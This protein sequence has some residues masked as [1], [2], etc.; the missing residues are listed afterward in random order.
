M[1]SFCFVLHVLPFL[2]TYFCGLG[3]FSDFTLAGGYPA[4]FIML[5]FW[6]WFGCYLLSCRHWDL[7]I[8]RLVLSTWNEKRT[9][10]IV[11]LCVDSNVLIVL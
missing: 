4:S 2:G 9:C 7:L 8:P 1:A 6:S 10:E 5:L 11:S 3:Y